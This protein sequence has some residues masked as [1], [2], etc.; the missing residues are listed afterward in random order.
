MAYIRYFCGNP[1]NEEDLKRTETRRTFLYKGTV[2][3]IRAYA[4]IAAELEEA[5]YS[6]VEITEIKKSRLLSQS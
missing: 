4:N 2:A 1:E 5:G 3:L 6:Q